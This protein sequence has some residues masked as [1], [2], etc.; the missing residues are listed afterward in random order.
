MQTLDASLLTLSPPL[1]LQ[2]SGIVEPETLGFGVLFSAL[3][4]TAL[5]CFPSPAL[6]A[7]RASMPISAV[8]AFSGSIVIRTMVAIRDLL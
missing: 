1:P 4:P 6:L 8:L 2:A 3:A 5:G 7:P